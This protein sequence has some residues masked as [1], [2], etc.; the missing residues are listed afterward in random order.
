MKAPAVAFQHRLQRHLALDR[1]VGVHL[2]QLARQRLHTGCQGG[3]KRQHG[4]GARRAMS[5]SSKARKGARAGPEATSSGKAWTV[6]V[7]PSRKAMRPPYPTSSAWRVDAQ[8]VGRE[9]RMRVCTEVAAECILT[10]SSE[11]PALREAAGFQARLPRT[12][13]GP[14]IRKR[15]LRPFRESRFA[16]ALPSVPLRGRRRLGN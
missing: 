6:T 16:L 9:V 4:S 13:S 3:R 7:S 14:G 1:H 12:R 15:N 10:S 5:A 8:N 11:P 2:A